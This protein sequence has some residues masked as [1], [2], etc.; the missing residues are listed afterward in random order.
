MLTDDG[1]LRRDPSGGRGRSTTLVA[2]YVDEDAVEGEAVGVANVLAPR[3]RQFTDAGGD[4]AYAAEVGGEWVLVYGSAPAD[5]LLTIVESLTDAD[6]LSLAQASWRASMAAS[7]RCAGAVERLLAD[8]GEPL[9][10]LPQRQRL[11][12]GGA[13]RPRGS[14]PPR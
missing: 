12:Q 11:L 2:T 7:R 8:R 3:W 5:D 6:A 10:A 4:T 1:P 9:A 14:A 13:A